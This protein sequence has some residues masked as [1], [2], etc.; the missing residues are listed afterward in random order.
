MT[1]LA[2]SGVSWSWIGLNIARTTRYLERVLTVPEPFRELLRAGAETCKP[3]D[4]IFRGRRTGTALSSRAVRFILRNSYAVRRLE[5]GLNLRELQQELG[6]ASVRT[7]E[8]YRFCLAPIVEDHPFSKVRK[9]QA[10]HAP[11]SPSQMSGLL[12]KP[13]HAP[14]LA[15]LET[16]SLHRLRLPFAPECGDSRAALFLRFLVNRVFGNIVRLR[17]PRSP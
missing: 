11:S 5:N 8:R 17:K 14:P 1:R 7:T 4:Y 2:T 12:P 10:R 15:G 16:I 13:S 9:L 6:H 3:D